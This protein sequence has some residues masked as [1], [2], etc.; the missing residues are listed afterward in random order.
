[1]SKNNQFQKNVVKDWTFRIKKSPL[2]N[3]QTKLLLLLHGHLGNENSMWI[4]AN[5]LPETYT[6]IAPRAPIKTGENQYSWHK[7][8]PHWPS[9]DDYGNLAEKLM[10]RISLLLEELVLDYDQ[11]HVMGFSQ[12][13]V[14]A[15]A[16]A[17]LYPDIIGKVAAVASFIPHSWLSKIDPGSIKNKPFF[18]AHGTEDEIIPIEKAASSAEWLETQGANITF[19]KAN[20]GHKISA[21]CF[22]GLENFFD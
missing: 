2:K 7:I 1:M 14:M 5:P 9:L 19:C 16:L 11:Y 6:F 12:G 13:A 15:Y 17:F 22:K 21:N 10:E 20:I 3:K 4:L 8:N 18:I